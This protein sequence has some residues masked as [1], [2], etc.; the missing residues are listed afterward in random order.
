MAIE[1]SRIG[2]AEAGPARANAARRRD[3][4]PS[5]RHGGHEAGAAVAI[6]GRYAASTMLPEA[7]DVLGLPVR[8]LDADNLIE[9]AVARTLAGMRTTFCYVNAHVANL[10]LHDD[11]LA[12]ALRRA[13]VLFAD[14]VSVVWASRYAARR[15]PERMTAN[16]YFPRLLRRCADEG[17]RLF[18]L[19]GKPGVAE[20]AAEA[21]RVVEPTV[22]IVGSRDGYFSRTESDEVVRQVNASGADMLLVGLSTPRQ[23]LWLAQQGPRLR[24]PARWCGGALLDY[25]AGLERPAPAWAC[26]YGTEW[27]YRLAVDP[28]GKWRRY[29]LGNPRFV[30]NT[31]AWA[32]RRRFGGQRSERRA[33]RC[34]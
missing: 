11:L 13:D 28:V 26:R 20:A 15:L 3:G 5:R 17:L 18:L 22:R 12:D 4:R 7:V 33:A 29:L 25:W 2:A 19:G 10:A 1:T 8:V 21:M 32:W 14:G 31:L 6:D 16:D 9:L 27:L 24:V 30:W 34:D 23:E